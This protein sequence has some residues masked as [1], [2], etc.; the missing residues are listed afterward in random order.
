MQHEGSPP[1]IISFDHCDVYFVRHNS[2]QLG[3]YSTTIAG[4]RAMSALT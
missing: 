4:R 2:L 3:R 1:L